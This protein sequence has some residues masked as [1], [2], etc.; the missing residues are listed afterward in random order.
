M[1]LAQ[2]SQR[3]VLLCR[4]QGQEPHL[5]FDRQ[6][7]EF[8][9]IL[10][11]SAGDEQEII[12]ENP[13]NFPVEVYSLEFDK[14]YLEEEKVSIPS[15]TNAFKLILFYRQMLLACFVVIF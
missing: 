14:N 15:D 8:G 5:V 12:V 2:S 4:G 11:H 6:L 1:R 10:P 3:I 9:P 13:C 7:V